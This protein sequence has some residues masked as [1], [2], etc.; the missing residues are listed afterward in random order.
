[1]TKT[2]PPTIRRRLSLIVGERLSQRHQLR[3]Q[4]RQSRRLHGGTYAALAGPDDV[5]K[6]TVEAR[7]ELE[8]VLRAGRPVEVQVVTGGG[9]VTR[10]ERSSKRQ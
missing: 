1:M 4:E 10:L 8:V 9:V 2:R 3:Q 5:L 7:S 6:E